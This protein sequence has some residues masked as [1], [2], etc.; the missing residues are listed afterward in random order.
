MAGKY[1]IIVLLGLLVSSCAQVGVI[2]GGDV[3]RYAPKPVAEDVVPLNE[4]TNFQGN[5][6]EIPFDEYFRL[7]NP[8]QNIRMVPPP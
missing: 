4:S 7:M 8:T 5:S 3:D 6:I 1:Y 2:S